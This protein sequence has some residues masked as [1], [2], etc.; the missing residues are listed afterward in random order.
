MRR[1]LRIR[2]ALWVSLAATS[3]VSGAAGAQSKTGTS[4]A[5]FLL[6]EPSARIA[7]MGNAGVTLFEGVQSVY[8]NPA[9]IGGLDKHAFAFS[10]A[11]WLADINYNYAAAALPL[12]KWG[13]AFAS[14]TSLRSGDIDVRTVEQPLGTGELF[15]VSDMAIGVGYGLRV[16]DRFAAGIQASY[17][18]ETIWHTSASTV[19]LN[20]GTL[21]ELSAN[22]LHIGASIS[23]FGTDSRYS[24]RDLRIIYDFDPS[25]NGDNGTLPG[26]QFTDAYPVPILFRVGLGLPYPVGKDGKLQL[27]VDAFHPSDNSESVSFGAEYSYKKTLSL[28]GGYQNLFLPDSEV[29][30]TL[31]AGLQGKLNKDLGYSLDYAWADQGRLDSTHRVTLGVTF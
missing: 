18:Q 30:L 19:V 9:A 4:I 12:G 2:R 23:N 28:R 7:G 22:G 25:R 15:H 11:E 6:I 20:L 29:G 17:V 3:L 13:N 5:D 14:V 26:E 27:A 24:G 31:G 8:Y 1:A 10:H 21:Y 16:S